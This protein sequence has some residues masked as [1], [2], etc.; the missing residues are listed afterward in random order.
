[1]RLYL[2]LRLCGSRHT[3]AQNSFWVMVFRRAK[4]LLRNVFMFILEIFIIIIIKTRQSFCHSDY[5]Y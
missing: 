4:P 5:L 3:F 1:M 2:F